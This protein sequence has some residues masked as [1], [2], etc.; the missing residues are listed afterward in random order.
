MQIVYARFG[1]NSV[2]ELR[3]GSVQGR[4]MSFLLAFDFGVYSRLQLERDIDR[5]R[6]DEEAIEKV[7]QIMSPFLQE[8][9]AQH[10]PVMPAGFRF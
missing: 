4:D 8:L 10:L 9:R 1:I 7:R 2:S 3:S 5:D 6:V